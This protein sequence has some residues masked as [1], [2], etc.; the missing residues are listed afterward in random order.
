MDLPKLHLL[1][2]RH[3]KTNYTGVFPD[4]TD[5]GMEHVRSVAN[6]QIPEWIKTFNVPNNR[7]AIISSPAPRAYGTASVIAEELGDTNPIIIRDELGPI[8]WKDAERCKIA[9][10]G[11]SG[12]GYIDYETEQVFANPK[13]FETPSEVR[14]RFYSFFAHYINTAFDAPQPLHGIL[15]SHYE[16][17]CNITRDMFGIVASEMTALQHVEP[18]A[19]SVSLTNNPRNVYIVGVF[20]DR[21]A[22]VLFDLI[23]QRVVPT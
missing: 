23:R 19:L 16:S 2:V 22:H 15:V 3:G 5:E 18:I 20:R 7:F 13:L 6:N 9:L 21:R 12:V 11:L 10:K 1:C 4:L 8:I 17:L 14:T